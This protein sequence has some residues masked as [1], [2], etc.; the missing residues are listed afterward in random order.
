MSGIYSDLISKFI[1]E[2]Y[3]ATIIC[4]IERR[5]GLNSRIINSNGV[6]IIQVKSLNVQKTN[7]FEKIVSTFLL[8]FIFF[9]AFYKNCRN[10]S[11]DIGLFTPPP[12][13]ITNF[14]LFNRMT[15]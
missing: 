7:I 13:F 10:E 3:D 6:K 9:S 5:F 4:P 2:G 8:E 1:S 12:I 15:I 11:Y 14:I